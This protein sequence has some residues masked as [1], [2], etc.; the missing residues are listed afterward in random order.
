MNELPLMKLFLGQYRNQSVKLFR[1][2]IIDRHMQ[3]IHTG[4][5]SHVKSGLKGQCDA[6]GFVRRPADRLAI[7]IE[8]EFKAARGR[9]S[10]GQVN[11]RDTCQ[12]WNVPWLLLEV[13]KE[14]LPTDTLTR[15]TKELNEFVS[16]L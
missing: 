14:E 3:D 5:V 15:W 12:N 4:A 9:L 6:H 10:E 7:P 2:N 11:W 13:G 1:R 16:S 8:I